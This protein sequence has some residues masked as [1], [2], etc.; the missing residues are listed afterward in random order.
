MAEAMAFGDLPLFLT[1]EQLS[2]LTG[3]TPA[4]I[5]RGIRERRI[6]A[7]KINGRWR[8]PRDT[9]FRNTREAMGDGEAQ[10]A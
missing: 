4:S 8:I 3:Q 6:V 2:E 1:P 7:D 5:R 9:V 10:G